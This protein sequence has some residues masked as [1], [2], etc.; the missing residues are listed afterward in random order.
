MTARFVDSSAQGGLPKEVDLLVVGSGP[1]GSAYARIVSER[2][3]GARIL[4]VEAG[5]R[6]TGVPGKHV[7]NIQDRTERARAVR[8]SEGRTA[9]EERTSMRAHFDAEATELAAAA[10]TFFVDPAAPG[11]GSGLLP[12]LAA[13][14]NV[15]GMGSHWGTA[16]PYPRGRE[17]VGFIPRDEWDAALDKAK[18][19]LAV[20]EEPLTDSP[21]WQECL[22]RLG[23][24]FNDELDPDGPVRNIPLACRRNPDGTLHWSGSDTVLGDLATGPRETFAIAADTLCRR[25]TGEGRRITGAVLEHRPTGHTERVSAKVVV[26]A[27]DALHTPQLLWASGIRPQALGRYFSEHV[28][29]GTTLTPAGLDATPD[30][31]ILHADGT[32]SGVGWIPLP[33]HGELHGQ[34]RQSVVRSEGSDRSTGMV[35]FSFMFAKEARFE[36]RIWFSQTEC[37]P[38]GMP[39]IR[40]DYEYTP[41]DLDL[42]EQAR[43]QVARAAGALGADRPTVMVQP[44]GTSL[45]YL[46]STRMGPADDG[47]SVCDSHSRVWGYDNLYLGGNNVIPTPVACNPTLTSMLLACRGAEQAA[48][49]TASSL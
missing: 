30:L 29:V 35:L 33:Q 13:S 6:L 17:R 39:A 2:V 9:G 37:D 14:R 32:S 27:G 43:R 21:E 23:K 49:L 31:S 40:Y 1:I 47:T 41:H 11:A 19:L 44:G 38:Y 10:G 15:G 45:H 26:V 5:P 8:L 4:M 18:Q 36:D 24:E 46:G 48:S 7:L 16:S 25:L 22:A 20:S 3:P 42:I 34:F 12:A 28:F